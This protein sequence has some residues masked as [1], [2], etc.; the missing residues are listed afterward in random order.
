[1]AT[2]YS[3]YSKGW[4]PSGASS[5]RKYRAVL[6]YSVSTTATTVSV[7]AYTQVNINAAVDAKYSG[8]MYA[9]NGTTYTGTATTDYSQGDKTKTIV[10]SK[11]YSWARGTTAQTKTIAGAVASSNGSWTGAWVTASASISVPALVSYNI[12]YDSNIPLSAAGT[13]DNM[14][15]NQLKYQSINA[16]LA[17]NIPI[18]EHWV[19]Q[20]WNTA[21]DGSGT[22]YVPGGTYSD[23]AAVTL[24]AQWEKL[25]IAP[26]I[27]NISFD[28]VETSSGTVPFDE[29]NY[30]C[31][32]LSDYISGDVPADGGSRYKQTAVTL[33]IT[34]NGNTHTLTALDSNTFTGSGTTKRIHYEIPTVG[35]SPS[36]PTSDS[37]PITLTFSTT[38]HDSTAYSAV[39][40]SSVYPIDIAA[41]ATMMMFGIP[42]RVKKDLYL[43]V[44]QNASVG[45]TD[46]DLYAVL[47]ALGWWND[48]NV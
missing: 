28:R 27:D 2:V 29:G 39:L 19:F 10:S 18:L 9:T 23:N 14:P 11:T 42:T 17:S 20:G 1:M 25:F 45:T 32:T 44:D 8:K 7:T 38:D 24:Y 33:V 12:T 40:P 13:V 30:L 41:D 43:D 48:V 36:Y 5:A 35:Y 3:A 26:I 31:V 4:T 46:G 34:E 21:A 22:D 6:V 15:A 37:Y 47:D 16:T